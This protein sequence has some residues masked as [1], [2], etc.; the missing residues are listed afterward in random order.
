[1][2][3][4]K[5]N[6]PVRT[7]TD[8]GLRAAIWRKESK[9]GDFYAVTFSRR[10]KRGEGEFDT[11]YSFSGSELLRLAKMAEQAYCDAQALKEASAIAPQLSAQEVL[12]GPQ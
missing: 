2:T 6:K 1:M 8:G 7:L 4:K 9:N 11:S 12:G 3:D 5:T 10:Y